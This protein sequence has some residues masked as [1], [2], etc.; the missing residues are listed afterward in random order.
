[1]GPGSHNSQDPSLSR[2]G[3]RRE[4]WVG[5]WTSVRRLLSSG[6][7]GWPF[8]RI[9]DV[10]NLLFHMAESQ[11]SRHTHLG[12]SVPVSCGRRIS[13]RQQEAAPE[14]NRSDPRAAAAQGPASPVL[15][16]PGKGECC[17]P[18]MTHLFKSFTFPRSHSSYL[19]KGVSARKSLTSLDAQLR[20][21]TTF[22]RPSV[23]PSAEGRGGGRTEPRGPARRSVP[24]SYRR[25]GL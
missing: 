20:E 24:A 22:S 4:F 3:P 11:K 14:R 6:G 12:E 5:I 16:S 8:A 18:E 1:M 23:R 21:T 10:V 17:G 25:P 19:G 13:G 15:P 7:T 9:R 2:R